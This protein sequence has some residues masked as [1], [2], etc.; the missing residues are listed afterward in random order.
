M[1]STALN[2][3][4]NNSYHLEYILCARQCPECFTYLN[5]F[6]PIEVGTV[7]TIIDKEIKGL[8]VS[9]LSHSLDEMAARIQTCTPLTLW[10]HQDRVYNLPSS[11]SPVYHSMRHGFS[12]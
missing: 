1:Y 10:F 8:I 2:K 6:N 11:E 3:Q 5:L 9:P 12:A 4:T 7:I